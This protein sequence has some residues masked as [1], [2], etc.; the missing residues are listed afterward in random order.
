MPEGV[1][2]GF[3]CVRMNGQKYETKYKALQTTNGEIYALVT[4]PI[5]ADTTTL[6]FISRAD[7]T[8]DGNVNTNSHD[9][10][11]ASFVFSEVKFLKSGEEGVQALAT[12]KTVAERVVSGEWNLLVS[13][14][15][16]NYTYDN[17]TIV[18]NTAVAQLNFSA[19]VLEELRAAGY[20]KLTFTMSAEAESLGR[21]VCR[22]RS[23][24]TWQSGINKNDLNPATNGKTKTVTF[25]LTESTCGA[26]WYIAFQVQD[27]AT[28]VISD[29]TLTLTGF[30]VS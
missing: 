2:E 4:L 15:E 27:T 29:S 1:T 30:T 23:G 25:D 10:V 20:T 21:I 19:E 5:G 22:W 12:E 28:A 18:K 17:G 3:I 26:G 16:S 7:Y 9:Q 14:A 13:N 6:Q 8:V 11:T 24:N